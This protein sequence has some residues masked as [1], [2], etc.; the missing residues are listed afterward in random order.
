MQNKF[1]SYII[2]TGL[3]I[4]SMFFGA[5]NLMYPINVGRT[6][7]NHWIIATLGFL[8]TATI[9]PLVG[10]LAIILCNGKYEEFF[11]KIGKIPGAIAIFACLIFIGPLYAM[12]RIVGLSSIMIAPF[13]HVPLIIFNILFLGLTF[14]LTFRESK[15]IKIL[16]NVISPTLLIALSIIIIKGIWSAQ[17]TEITAIPAATLFWKNFIY[18]YNTLDLLGAIFFSSI[19]MSILTK[20]FEIKSKQDLKRLAWTGL[21]AGILGTFLLSLVY[22]GLSILGAYHGHLG[23]SA[24]NEAEV[25]SIISMSV[26]GSHGAAIISIAVIGACLS[27]VIA[28]AAIF[29]EYLQKIS[30]GKLSYLQALTL[31]LVGTG[32]SSSFG[33][34][35]LLKFYEPIIIIAHPALIFL[36]LAILA[37]KF[38]GYKFIK[39]P[40]LI[41]FIATVV[42][43]FL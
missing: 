8:M 23:L 6:A 43:H 29:S 16:G 38:F 37:H 18:G 35:N 28:L 34:T 7:A 14:L 9:L 21:Q 41:I 4:F 27:T 40:T 22:I 26:L 19:V 17:S 3:A 10:L 36:T 42:I 5:G 12:P 31:T 2:P 13:I 11:D 33:L 15:I 24:I 30:K 32:L 20:D 25:F 1:K 39:I